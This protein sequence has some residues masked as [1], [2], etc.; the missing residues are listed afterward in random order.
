MSI[1]FLFRKKFY[2]S[3]GPTP[4][5]YSLHNVVCIASQSIQ[6]RSNLVTNLLNTLKLVSFPV[7]EILCTLSKF[8]S[9]A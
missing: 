1:G 4:T 6:P 3:R 9:L 2:L 7:N 8:S 5:T